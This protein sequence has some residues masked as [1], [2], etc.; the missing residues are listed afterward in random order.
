MN[1]PDLTVSMKLFIKFGLTRWL[2]IMSSEFEALKA[3][4]VEFQFSEDAQNP[5]TSKS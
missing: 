5:T 1:F 4:V 2:V 3:I